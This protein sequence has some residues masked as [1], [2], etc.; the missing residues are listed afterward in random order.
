MNRYFREETW[1][2]LGG[3]CKAKHPKGD[4]HELTKLSYTSQLRL[5]TAPL[6]HSLTHGCMDTTNPC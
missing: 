1:G 5:C 2:F 3:K 4:V 6:I